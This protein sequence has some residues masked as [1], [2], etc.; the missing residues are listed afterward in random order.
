MFWGEEK[1]SCVF[2]NDI[3]TNNLSDGD[4]QLRVKSVT[5]DILSRLISMVG[6]PC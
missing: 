3:I 1:V 2:I 5:L 6:F 4:E